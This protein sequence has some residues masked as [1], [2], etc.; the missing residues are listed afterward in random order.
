MKATTVLR[1]TPFAPGFGTVPDYVA[2]RKEEFR[3]LGDNLHDIVENRQADGRLPYTPPAPIVLIGPRGVGKTLLLGWVEEQA[4]DKGAH[5]ADLSYMEDNLGFNMMLSLIIDIAGEEDEQFWKALPEINL[6]TGGFEEILAR[7]REVKGWFKKMFEAKL[8]KQPVV[9]LMDEVQ[10][11]HTGYLGMIM[12]IAGELINSKYPLMVLLAGT[13][14]MKITLKDIESSFTVRGQDISINLLGEKET[15]AGLKQPFVLRG[16]EVDERALC[17]MQSWTDGYPYFIQTVGDAVWD[18]LRDEKEEERRKRVD[19]L[20]VEKAHKDL[21][22]Q[23]DG[24][25]GTL[26]HELQASNLHVYAQQIADIIKLSDNQP[27]LREVLENELGRMN[28]KF[29]PEHRAKEV[30]NTLLD[31]GFLWPDD[32]GLLAP[33]IPSFLGFVEMMGAIEAREREELLSSK[34]Q[35]FLRGL[36]TAA[37]DKEG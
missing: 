27:V 3:R 37:K 4:R 13:P 17:K 12:Q 14:D 29:R 31:R 23:H 7:K 1:S 11:Y 33:A 20:L 8:K 32:K 5:I 35:D 26:Y 21:K 24:F 34:C 16:V 36:D 30:V 10:H 28:E 6:P 19:L 22:E 25:Y 18:T 15:R 9:L 2:G